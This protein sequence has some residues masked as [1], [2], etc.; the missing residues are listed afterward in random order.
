LGAHAAGAARDLP[1]LLP[2]ALRAG[3]RDL[4][5]LIYLT[6]A[7]LHICVFCGVGACVEVHALRFAA[8]AAVATV[9]AVA[10]VCWTTLGAKFIALHTATCNLQPATCNLTSA[11]LR[12]PLAALRALAGDNS[13][14][15]AFG[16][17]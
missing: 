10:V 16:T 1:S 5:C 8:N 17:I 12:D 9:T 15:G 6:C 2:H 3:K 7:L 4:I 14:I 13:V 11:D